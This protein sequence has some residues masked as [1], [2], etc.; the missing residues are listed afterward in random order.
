[1][2]NVR[3][4]PAWVDW[5]A[6]GDIPAIIPL[7]RKQIAFHPPPSTRASPRR[8]NADL[9]TSRPL[10]YPPVHLSALIHPSWFTLSLATED[11]YTTKLHG[12][13]NTNLTIE[14]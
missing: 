11:R 4:I 13:A 5:P 10:L 8:L 3:G 7:L 14:L 9:F 2:G 12:Y 6:V 1:M